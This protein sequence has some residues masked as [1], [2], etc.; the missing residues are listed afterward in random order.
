MPQPRS[1]YIASLA[2]LLG[3]A[4]SCAIAAAEPS[5]PTNVCANGACAADVS[6]SGSIQWHPGHYMSIRS[7]HRNPDKE[8]PF[9]DAIGNEPSIQGVV[10]QW[11]WRDLEI[12]KGN[13]DF[14]SIDTYLKKI[15]SLP[16]RKRLIIRIEERGFSSQTVTSVPNYLKSDTGYNGG[17]VPMA[18]GVVA[19]IWEGPVMDRLIALYAALAA[20][21]DGNP[22]VEG[23][24]MSETS[25]GFSTAYPAP[26]TFSN[27]A[28]LTQFKRHVI[29]SRSQWRHSQV[30]VST[31]YLGSDAQM[32]DLIKTSVTSKATVG[33][34]DVFTRAWV[35]S[36]KRALQSDVIVRGEAGSDTDYRGNVAIKAEVQDTELGGYIATFTPAELYDVAFNINHANYIFWDRNDYA[37]GPAQ[38]WSTGILPFIQSVNGKTYTQCPASFGNSCNTN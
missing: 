13:Y 2:A 36:G 27:G 9:I 24:S 32:E 21:Y 38:Q 14:S 34:P 1:H 18:N 37:G 35:E 17:E 28:L 8:L 25:I 33:G 20:K 10:V 30:F 4:S 12:T 6:A 3:I 5:P 7:R 23:I 31:N 15:S 29:A 22:S 26:A 19:R 11:L 16:T